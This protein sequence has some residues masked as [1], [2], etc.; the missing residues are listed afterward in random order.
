MRDGRCFILFYS[1]VNAQTQL[2]IRPLDAKGRP[3]SRDRQVF[4]QPLSLIQ[5]R[6]AVHPFGTNQFVVQRVESPDY[7]N[8]GLTVSTYRI[9]NDN[10]ITRLSEKFTDYYNNTTIDDHGAMASLAPGFLSVFPGDVTDYGKLIAQR[11]SATGAAIGKRYVVS[12]SLTGVS[13]PRIRRLT[14]GR[15]A[16]AWSYNAQIRLRILDASGK[17]AGPEKGIAMPKGAR[18]SFAFLEPMADG[19]FVI[20][21]HEYSTAGRLKFIVFDSDARIVN[22]GLIAARAEGADGF[23]NLFSVVR[24]Q[25]GGFAVVYQYSTGYPNMVMA[26]KEYN[27]NLVQVR[28]ETQVLLQKTYDIDYDAQKIS[29][30]Q[31]GSNRGLISWGTDGTGFDDGSGRALL[32]ISVP[33]K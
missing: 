2:K 27:R 7:Y 15:F 5:D 21:F 23:E 4:K 13:E 25:N 1:G 32:G 16:I 12:Q 31:S 8:A 10:T 22:A 33:L 9:E 18:A 24:K 6:L 17:P 19:K 26:Y 28:G 29:I 11:F 14:T 30:I 20:F 3:I